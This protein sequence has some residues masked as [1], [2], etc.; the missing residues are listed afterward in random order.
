MTPG[1]ALYEAVRVHVYGRTAVYGDTVQWLILPPATRDAWERAGEAVT[2]YT[3]DRDA[4]RDAIEA[5]DAKVE[6]LEGQL[7]GRRGR[8]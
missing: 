6:R 1:E 8:K 7:R 4:D 2:G 5:L 3:G